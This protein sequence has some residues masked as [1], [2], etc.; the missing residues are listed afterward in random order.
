MRFYVL[1]D[2]IAFVQAID[3]GASVSYGKQLTFHH[4]IYAFA[5][6]DRPLCMLLAEL[7]HV[8]QE[9]YEQFRRSTFA[10][11]QGLR[12]L[13][14]SRANRDWFFRL[15][16]G[17]TLEV[18]FSSGVSAQVTVSHSGKRGQR[19]FL[20]QFLWISA[21]QAETAFRFL[22]IRIPMVFREKTAGM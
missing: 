22:W 17:Q 3:S 4:S 6:E 1:R 14:L 13:N 16:E 11:V 7:V 18:E 9:H 2:L 20:L 5:E 21:V 15:M 10:T 19:P 12:Q 8:Y